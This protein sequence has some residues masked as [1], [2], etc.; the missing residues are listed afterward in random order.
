MA[1]GPIMRVTVKQVVSYLIFGSV[2]AVIGV[3]LFG[4]KLDPAPPA[5]ECCGEGEVCIDEWE[6][7]KTEIGAVDDQAA[8]AELLKQ[9]QACEAQLGVTKMDPERL[10]CGLKLAECKGA[11]EECRR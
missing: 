5:G 1:L 3:Y 11:L 4:L 9:V 10:K 2:C 6:L 7:T 8:A